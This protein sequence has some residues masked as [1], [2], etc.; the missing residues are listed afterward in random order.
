MNEPYH[1]SKPSVSHGL[2]QK[3]TLWARIRPSHEPSGPMCPRLKEINSHIDV[4]NLTLSVAYQRC[5]VAIL[6]MQALD[7]MRVGWHP[8]CFGFVLLMEEET[9]TVHAA[10]ASLLARLPTQIGCEDS[11]ESIDKHK[12]QRVKV[13]VECA[14]P[15]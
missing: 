6:R 4:L 11:D 12:T 2:Q 7:A 5:D 14:W 15:C 3:E 1:W 13:V 10:T 8:F 9:S